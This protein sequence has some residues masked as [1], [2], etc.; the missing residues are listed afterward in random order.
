MISTFYISILL[1]LARF[2][3]KNKY[4]HKIPYI[5]ILLITL[6]QPHCL[7]YPES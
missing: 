5:G 4:Y 6:L 1:K 2:A 3:D 7:S